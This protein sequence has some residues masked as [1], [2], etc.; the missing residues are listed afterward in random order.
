MIFFYDQG[1]P[2]WFFLLLK[3]YI[4]TGKIYVALDVLIIVKQY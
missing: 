4:V 1:Y 2:G 3:I